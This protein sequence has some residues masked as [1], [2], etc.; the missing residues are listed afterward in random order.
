MRRR[1]L[2]EGEGLIDDNNRGDEELYVVKTPNSTSADTKRNASSPQRTK[3]NGAIETPAKNLDTH[4]EHVHL[5]EFLVAVTEQVIDGSGEIR[6]ERM[7][8]VPGK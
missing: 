5:C 3:R 4:V 7:V 1:Y 8:P 2:E 6:V